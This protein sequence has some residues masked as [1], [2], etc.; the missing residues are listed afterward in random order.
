MENKHPANAEL[1]KSALEVL[2]SLYDEI[3]GGK[4]IRWSKHIQKYI[5]GHE[6]ESAPIFL[7]T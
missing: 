4:K 5:G 1:K 7:F 6:S 2:Y 3:E